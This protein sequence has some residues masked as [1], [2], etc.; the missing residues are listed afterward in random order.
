MRKIS[1]SI[2]INSSPERVFDFIDNPE[3]FLV[4]WPSMVEVAGIQKKPNGGHN[5]DWAYKMGGIR[6][7]GHSESVR[8]ERPRLIES[9]NER[10]IPS[11]FRWTFD[12]KNGGTLLNVDI[13]YSI[14]TP[15]VGKLAEAVVAKMNEHEMETVLANIRQAV[16]AEAQPGARDQR[17]PNAPVR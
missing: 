7:H 4:V 8:V 10:G 16:E 3:N 15:V 12:A 1:R 14:P 6:F 11:R 2:L 9:R 13:D 17:A 5:Y